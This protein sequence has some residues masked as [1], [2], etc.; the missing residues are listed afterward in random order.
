MTNIWRATL[1]CVTCLLSS[2]MTGGETSLFEV[3]IIWTE[4][5]CSETSALTAF[6][7]AKWQPVS[8]LTTLINASCH[9]ANNIQITFCLLLGYWL[10]KSP[11]L[12]EI[13]EPI[14]RTV[15]T[16]FGFT[17][18]PFSC[19]VWRTSPP[20]RDNCALLFLW[21]KTT[22][23]YSTWC[24]KTRTPQHLAHKMNTAG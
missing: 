1:L 16:Y 9:M 15:A 4:K 5:Y 19:K 8:K 12:Q 10:R 17:L 22:N 14:L 24:A 3:P 20:V 18:S 2:W 6:W 23:M 13:S 11:E 21:S 7:P